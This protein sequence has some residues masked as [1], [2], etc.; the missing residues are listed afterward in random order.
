MH[1]QSEGQNGMRLKTAPE[2]QSKNGF[3]LLS[4]STFSQEGGIQRVTRT[5]LH[6][7]RERWPAMPLDLYS[8]QDS[9]CQG[10]DPAF[11]ADLESGMMRYHPYGYSRSRYSA[12][13]FRHLVSHHPSLVVTEH[14]HLNVIP[15]LARRFASFPWVSLVHYLELLNLTR[16]RQRALRRPDLLV[17]VS[18]FTEQAA[19]GIL[20]DTSPPIAVCHLGLPPGYGDATGE[21]N[22]VPPHL[23]GRR[24][25]LIVGRMAD[26]GRDKG[27]EAL[28]RSMPKIGRRVPEALLVIV[29]RGNDETRLRQLT[30]N[31]G[32]EGL[33]HFAGCVPDQELPAYYEAAEIFA[34]PSFAEGFGLVYLEAMY[35]AKPCIAG[36]RDAAKEVVRDGETG[37]LVEPGN[38]GQLQAALL[39]LLQDRELARS[40]GAAGRA[41]LDHNFTY[42]HFADRM[43]KVLEPLLAVASVKELCPVR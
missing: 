20:G 4:A 9:K 39:R 22:P 1:P 29:G 26:R 8:L 19:R 28:I 41:R 30:S 33:V 10:V 15:W 5:L 18:H 2:V 13:S 16:L 14:V 21:F 36:N 24:V 31:L 38:D 11:Q 17:A 23:V 25:I 40:M 6:C 7:L 27:H 3:C 32:A 42:H 34:M 35:H 12:A 43:Q 37:I